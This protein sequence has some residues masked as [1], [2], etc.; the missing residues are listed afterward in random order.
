MLGPS[1]GIALY[2]ASPPL[3]WAGTFVLAMA[4]SLLTLAGG[5]ARGTVVALAEVR[6]AER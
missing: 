1:M 3:L 2:Q 4:A 6:S 5:R